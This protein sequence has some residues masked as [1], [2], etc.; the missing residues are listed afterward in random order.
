MAY[1][2]ANKYKPYR[3]AS[4]PEQLCLRGLCPLKIAY[5][6]TK[7]AMNGMEL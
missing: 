7:A 2:R 6:L 5:G 3:P 1:E 4:T